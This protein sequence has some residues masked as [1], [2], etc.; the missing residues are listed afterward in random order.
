ME[1]ALMTALSNS[2]LEAV[3]QPIVRLGHD[4]VIGFE[5]L[6]RWDLPG[7]GAVAPSEFIALAEDAGLIG[8]LGEWML[9]QACRQIVEWSN[10]S[11]FVSVNVSAKQF[12]KGQLENTLRR[13]LNDTG[14]DPTRLV[15]E[16]TESVLI[17]DMESALHQLSVVRS[18]GVRIAVDDFGTGYSGLSYLQR[19][20]ITIVK[21]DRSFLNQLTE[22]TTRTS[23][24]INAVV[25]L[26]HALG[27][28]VVAEGVEGE[29]QRALLAECGCDW[30]QG[31][32]FARPL[33]AN[34]AA[35]LATGTEAP[36]AGAAEARGTH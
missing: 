7:T 19:F 9:E 4:D 32:Y 5:A 28:I 23:A 12:A 16:I 29:R 1:L 18:L 35:K 26:A 21:L 8:S 3:Y 31:F 17:A 14:A 11:T 10:Q 6:A 27:Y 30:A 33:A 20:P 13:V 24:V 34:D 36:L 15:L 25:Q 2:E 22:T